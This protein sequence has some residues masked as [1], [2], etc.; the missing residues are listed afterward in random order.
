MANSTARINE[1]E[2][3]PF[4]P[5]N[6]SE[7]RIAYFIAGC[8]AASGL[9]DVDPVNPDSDGRYGRAVRII[10]VC[11]EGAIPDDADMY[12]IPLAG[13]LTLNLSHQPAE[14]IAQ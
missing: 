10:M 6:S 4:A 8:L 11:L 14:R 13:L 1:S 12:E 5:D 9:L 7:T 3:S 2:K